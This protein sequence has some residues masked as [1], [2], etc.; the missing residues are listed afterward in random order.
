MMSDSGSLYATPRV[1]TDVGQCH[2]YHTMDI[3]GH[4]LVPGEWDL[5]GG[6]DDYLG[7]ADLRGKRVLEV[8]TASGFLCF[9]MERRGADVVAYDLSDR[10][11]WD[12]VPYARYDAA[13]HAESFRTH[14]RRLNDGFWLAHRAHG[15]R[16]RVVY[17][18]V[19]A[20]PAAIGPVDVATFG[21]VLIHLRDP[22]LA[23]QQALRLT[24]E[25]AIVTD[26]MGDKP[27]RRDADAPVFLPDPAT[28][29]PKAS[30]WQL[31]PELIQRF[32]ATLGF[33]DSRVSHHRQA[34]GGHKLALYT[35]VARRTAGQVAGG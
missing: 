27:G 15:S 16:A 34:F 28:C 35:V 12:M 13:A 10:Q 3:P 25:T 17:G 2:F 19:Y 31:P 8:G 23:L 18:T 5:R 4:G 32:L 33:E 20:V 14:I 21:C 29:E 11:E 1:V 6:V 7:H 22:F 30:W 24:R 9:E 26:M